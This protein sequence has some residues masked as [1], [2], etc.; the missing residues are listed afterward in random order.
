MQDECANPKFNLLPQNH[1][2][3]IPGHCTKEG[4]EKYFSRN[5]DLIHPDNYKQP[6]GLDGLTLSKI[7]H[8]T[9]GLWSK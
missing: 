9:R 5:S 3:P 7:V 4:T 6:Y 2:D 1:P 8:G